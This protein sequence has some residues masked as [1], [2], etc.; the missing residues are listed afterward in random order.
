MTQ[1]IP[2]VACRGFAAFKSLDALDVANMTTYKLCPAWREGV[3][4][5][6]IVGQGGDAI[7]RKLYKRDLHL[8]KNYWLRLTSY[9]AHSDNSA[10]YA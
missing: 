10:I 2:E 3:R 6:L 4:L 8:P 7:R 1:V 5:A 9:S